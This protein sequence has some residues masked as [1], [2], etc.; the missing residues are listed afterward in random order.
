MK[1]FRNYF[2]SVSL[3]GKKLSVEQIRRIGRRFGFYMRD[4]DGFRNAIE[5]ETE[6]N[7]DADRRESA[8]HE[9]VAKAEEKKRS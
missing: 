1:P 2:S 4:G 9:A 7:G 3:S 6:N 8:F 5:F